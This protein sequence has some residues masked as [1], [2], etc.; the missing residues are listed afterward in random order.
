VWPLAIA[1]EGLTAV[2][3]AER[4]RALGRIEATLEPG[5]AL[6]ESVDPSA[7]RR[8][9]R[10]WFSWADMLYVELVLAT[11]GIRIGG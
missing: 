2:D 8:H 5:G 3:A 10:D 7:P 1:V 6:H 11:A 4:E 9:S